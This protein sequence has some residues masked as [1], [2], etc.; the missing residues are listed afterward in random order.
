MRTQIKKFY[1]YHIDPKRI[2]ARINDGQSDL[3][4]A[5]PHACAI[6]KEQRHEI[7]RFW[8]PYIKSFV[9]RWAFNIRWFDVYNRTNVFEEKLEWYIPDSYYY[10]V[11]DTAFN[12]PIRCR[13][14]DDKDLYDLYFHDVN[15]A[16][17]I[18]RKEDNTFLDANYS[19]ISNSRAMAICSNFEGVILK[20]SVDSCS[21]SG[22]KKWVAGKDSEKTLMEMLNSQGP[23]IIQELIHQHESLT[24]FNATCVN[25][26]RLVT[27]AMG[28]QIDVVT[29]VVIMGGPGAFTNHL[30]G[31]GLICG[32]LPNG[33]LRSIA[34][35]S[36][37]NQ[38]KQHPNGAIFANCKIP[39]YHK[40]VDLVK[41]LA[42]RLFGMSRLTAWD[43]T[44]DEHAEPIL[45]EANL[46]WGGVVQKAAGPVFGDRTKE[47]LEYVHY[48][49]Q[50]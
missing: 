37:L 4:G 31:G 10:A 49:K 29:A 27:L 47:V 40:C 6:S 18:C 23:F 25:T 19:I 46:Q 44:L 11:I 17:T 32:I 1:D 13:Y 39:N 26:T 50:C 14:M 24:I 30:H 3:L 28:D 7:Q 2:R 8:K 36:K 35:D 9:E 5:L 15:Q 34:F 41:D 21:G 42:P 12:D 43:I 33:N 22:I 20:P 45:I 38:Y 48:K 16:R